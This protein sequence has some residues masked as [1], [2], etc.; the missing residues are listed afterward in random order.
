MYRYTPQAFASDNLALALAQEAVSVGDD[1]LLNTEQR[2]FLYMPF[3]RSE[4]IKIH[5]IDFR[6]FKE[7]CPE[8]SFNFE[9]KHGGVIEKFGRYPHRNSILGRES[10]KEERVF[11]IQPHSSF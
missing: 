11:L 10:T 4:S 5:D 1:M 3:M 7:N 2:S 9:I 6:L 8:S